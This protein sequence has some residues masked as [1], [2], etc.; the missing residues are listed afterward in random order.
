MLA[1][2]IF[3]QDVAQPLV[4]PEA[5]P[6]NHGISENNCAFPRPV[7]GPLRIAR[8]VAIGE[9]LDVVASTFVEVVPIWPVPHSENGVDV[10]EKQIVGEVVIRSARTPVG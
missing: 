2:T 3:F 5:K 10:C 1:P 9:V 8:A 6:L 7:D 4:G